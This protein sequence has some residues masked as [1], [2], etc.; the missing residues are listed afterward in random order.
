MPINDKITVITDDQRKEIKANIIE[1]TDE[2]FVE[3]V[4]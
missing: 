1:T 3:K 2:S 4:L